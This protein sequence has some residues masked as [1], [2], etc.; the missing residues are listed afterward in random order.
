M[1]VGRIVAAGR[2]R[3]G[4]MTLLYR[5]SSRSFPDRRIVIGEDAAA[6][7]R[8]EGVDA[9]RS[10]YVYY[11]CYRRVGQACVVTN[12]SHT[13]LIAE[14]L[15]QGLS[16]TDAVLQVLSFLGYERDDLSTPRI[17]VAFDPARSTSEVVFGIAGKDHFGVW[18]QRIAEGKVACISTYGATS[19]LGGALEGGLSSSAA[20]DLAPELMGQGLFAGF[21]HPICS[22]AVVL[23]PDGRNV[24]VAA[25]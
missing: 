19:E 13:D 6:V 14:R 7:V 24:D 23:S 4:K 2:T 8:S 15:R 21:S 1:Y 22:L 5:V 9:A 11:N 25:S 20:V 3:D 18:T 12:G 16:P 10:E 17:A